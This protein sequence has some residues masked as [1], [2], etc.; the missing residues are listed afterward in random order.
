MRARSRPVPRLER[1]ERFEDFAV[2]PVGRF[3]SG[4]SFLVWCLKPDLCGAA[5]WGHLSMADLAILTRVY[6][7]GEHGGIARPCDFVLDARRLKG[8]ESGV[9]ETVERSTAAR[10]D[11][12]RRRLRRQALVRGRGLLGAAVS[13]FYTVIE[14]DLEARVFTDLAPALAWLDESDSESCAQVE[15]LIA[16]AVAGM[17]FVDRLRECLAMRAG[18]RPAIDDTARSLAVSS[19]CRSDSAREFRLRPGSYDPHDHDSEED[20]NRS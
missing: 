19:G 1:H 12:L 7:R 10:V 3:A 5:I 6:D 20:A 14:A 17:S 11:N 16:D 13:G 15:A 18:G 8:L 4:R 2:D 9:F